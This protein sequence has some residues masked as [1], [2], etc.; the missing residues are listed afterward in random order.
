MMGLQMSTT[1][2]SKQAG[3]HQTRRS[4]TVCD[5][6]DQPPHEK[7]LCVRILSQDRQLTVARP[8]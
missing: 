2:H 4:T 5:R 8:S 7:Y 1:A 6:T 3:V